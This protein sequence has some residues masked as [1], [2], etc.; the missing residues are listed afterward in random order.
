MKN[1]LKT[2]A[3]VGVGVALGHFAFKSKNP[4]V[5]MVFGVAGGILAN[6]LLKSRGQ[7]IDEAENVTK[8][9]LKQVNEDIEATL[10]TDEPAKN[11]TGEEGEKMAFNPNVGY[12]TPQ[13][14][15]EEHNPEEYMDISF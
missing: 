14:T 12:I 2:V 11:T 4:L 15:V 9:Y 8:K 13:G 1:Q 6:Q 3:G 7:K 10:V 5:L